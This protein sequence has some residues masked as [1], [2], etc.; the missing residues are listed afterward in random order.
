MTAVMRDDTELF[1]LF[2]QFMDNDS[3]KCWMTD[4][5]FSLDNVTASRMLDDRHGVQPGLRAGS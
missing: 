2:K 3:F 1:E 5:V 4:T